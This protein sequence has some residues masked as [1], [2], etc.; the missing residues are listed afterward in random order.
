MASKPI[1]CQFPFLIHLY[2]TH[3][4]T[5]CNI[6]TEIFYDFKFVNE[7]SQRLQALYLNDD[8]VR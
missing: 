7:V 1:P 4:D 6:E 8:S 2:L 5:E 3:E